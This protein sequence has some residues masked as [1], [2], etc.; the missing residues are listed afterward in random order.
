L[1]LLILCSEI[2]EE[3]ISLGLIGELL[4]IRNRVILGILRYFKYLQ[5]EISF[6][7]QN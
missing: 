1:I 4:Q 6:W 7:W 3:Y 2:Y 5:R